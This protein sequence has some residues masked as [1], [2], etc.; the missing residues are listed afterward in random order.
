LQRS[1]VFGK[2]LQQSLK[3]QQLYSSK[4]ILLQLV[5]NGFVKKKNKFCS[6]C[7]TLYKNNIDLKFEKVLIIFIAKQMTD[8]IIDFGYD[9]RGKPELSIRDIPQQINIKQK[10]YDL[11]FAQH[12]LPGIEHFTSR[13]NMQLEDGHLELD[14]LLE[15]SKIC[16]QTELLNPKLLIFFANE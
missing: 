2:S 14:D 6:V 11:L 10:R 4:K 5:L 12:F 15:E 7:K 8:H 9:N 13:V 1:I 3:N 16:R